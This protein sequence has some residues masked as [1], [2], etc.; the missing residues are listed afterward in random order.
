MP[1]PLLR[2]ASA[3]ALG[4]QTPGLDELQKRTGHVGWLLL[5]TKNGNEPDGF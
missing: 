2:I 1:L 5:S 4:G 3:T